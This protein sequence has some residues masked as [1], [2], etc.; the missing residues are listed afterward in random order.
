VVTEEEEITALMAAA[1]LG[2]RAPLFGVDRLE[3]IAESAPVRSTR[4][5]PDPV[6]REKRDPRG[7]TTGGRA[8]GGRQRR[9]RGY[10]SV[11][12]YLVEHGARTDLCNYDNQR[13]LDVARA[14]RAGESTVELLTRLTEAE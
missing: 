6:A 1:G 11:V 4:R 5:E 7:G 3:R 12:A 13:P 2:G 14:R 10:A 8:R 9:E